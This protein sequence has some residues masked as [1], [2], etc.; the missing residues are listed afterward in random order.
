MEKDERI[1]TYTDAELAEMQRRGETKTDWAYLDALADEELEA[2]ID[3]E[4][5]GEFDWSKAQV[6]LPDVATGKVSVPIERDL[7]AWFAQQPGG[8]EAAVNEALRS[9]VEA[10][11]PAEPVKQ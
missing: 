6:G 4:D 3:F 8:I 10:L 2:S 1:V 7:V 9:H 11:Q 5:E